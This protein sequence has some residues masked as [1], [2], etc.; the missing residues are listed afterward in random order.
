MLLTKQIAAHKL[1]DYLKHAI[2]QQ[3]LAEWAEHALLEGDLEE[4]SA[5]LAWPG[6]TVKVYCSNWDITRKWKLKWHDDRAK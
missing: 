5:R 6:T 4:C 1:A 2:T 3:E